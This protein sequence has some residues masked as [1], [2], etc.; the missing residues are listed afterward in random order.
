MTIDV[1][2]FC[3]Y[4]DKDEASLLIPVKQLV[5]TKDEASRQFVPEKV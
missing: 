3:D 1:F 4:S 2:Y 5:S